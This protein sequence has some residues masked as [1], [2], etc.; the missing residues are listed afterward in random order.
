MRYPLLSTRLKSILIDGLIII[1]GGMYL[2]SA[3]FER[4]GEVPDYWRALTLFGLFF[5]YEPVSQTLGCTLGNFLT[6]IRVRKAN[7]EAK[8]INIFQAMIRFIVKTLFGWVSFVTIHSNPKRQALHD[9]AAGTV[10][11]AVKG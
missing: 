8:R 9:L 1:I 7:D 4:L 5:V 3:I 10:M 11:I 6:G 2:A